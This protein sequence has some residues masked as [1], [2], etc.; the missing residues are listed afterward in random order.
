MFSTQ[1]DLENN[2]LVIFDSNCVLCN[3]LVRFLIRVDKKK[4]LLFT[5]FDSKIWKQLNANIPTNS[6]SLIYYYKGEYFIQ[7]E[8]VIKIVQA[9]NYPWK[10]FLIFKFIP[11]SFREKTYKFIAKNRFRI[12]GR[13]DNCLIPP[14]EIRE[15]YLL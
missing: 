10:A 6:D 13:K 12:F 11:F 7:S 15:R 5:T 14:P 1:L 2:A 8:A 9:L 4:R 3:S